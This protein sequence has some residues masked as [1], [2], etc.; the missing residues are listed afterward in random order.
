[1]KKIYTFL[2]SSLFSLS[3]FAYNNNRISI[4]SSNY[5]MS[6]R[7]EVDGRQ[8]IM[9]DNRATLSNLSIGSHNVRIYRERRRNDFGNTGFAGKYEIIYATSVY[10][11]NDYQVDIA[12]NQL[13]RVQ[14]D[15]YSTSPDDYWYYDTNNSGNDSGSS[16]TVTGNG[17]T[18]NYSITGQEIN[19][20][21]PRVCKQRS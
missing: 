17:N 1:M 4:S 18:F 5:T 9:Q 13:G 10:L 11:G 7:V 20:T 15:S 19:I 2:V 16:S 8:V 6:L 21:K 3:L 12:I 14:V